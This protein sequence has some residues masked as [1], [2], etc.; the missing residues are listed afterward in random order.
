MQRPTTRRG[1][2]V[3]SPKPLARHGADT[4]FRPR[5]R[6]KRTILRRHSDTRD[7]P[8]HLA[9]GSL[10]PEGPRR[11]CICTRALLHPAVPA[12]DSARREPGAVA[13]TSPSLDTTESCD[14]GVAA[15]LAH[16]A[17]Q[18]ARR[19]WGDARRAVKAEPQE[20]PT[21]LPLLLSEP[22]ANPRYAATSAPPL[23]GGFAREAGH[24]LT[25]VTGVTLGVALLEVQGRRLVAPAPAD[26]D[27]LVVD[28]RRSWEQIVGAV[29]VPLSIDHQPGVTDI[30]GTREGR[31]V[32]RVLGCRT[33]SIRRLMSRSASSPGL[34]GVDRGAIRDPGSPRK[35]RAACPDVSSRETT[36]RPVRRNR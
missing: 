7:K 31:C 18:D 24:G 22:A 15:G 25:V 4:R 34:P 10:V 9:G 3:L 26:I 33:Q 28:G 6:L 14:A 35:A 36:K 8:A 21:K 20:R 23:D 17:L 12:L 32:V 27:G 11:L 13:A 2:I 19:R 29:A 30:R 16:R 5:A 1:A